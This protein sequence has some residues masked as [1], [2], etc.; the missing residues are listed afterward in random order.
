MLGGTTVQD[1]TPALLP[2]RVRAGKRGAAFPPT[3]HSLASQPSRSSPPGTAVESG[4]TQGLMAPRSFVGPRSRTAV[5]TS[6]CESQPHH[7]PPHPT[8]GCVWV[9]TGL[10][11]SPLYV[12]VRARTPLPY[13]TTPP[14]N[15]YSMEPSINLRPYPMITR[16]V[17]LLW[18]IRKIR[19]N[20]DM[21][22]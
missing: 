20:L 3:S 1:G 21:E 17:L 2:E 14:F 15:L 13:S 9:R 11:L 10:L 22:C 6:E 16:L 5:G 4:L 18:D 7:H 8:P 12:L 19:M